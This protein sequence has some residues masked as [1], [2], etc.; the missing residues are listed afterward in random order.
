M[1]AIP[2]SNS[3]SIT[4]LPKNKV[5]KVCLKAVKKVKIYHRLSINP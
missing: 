5:K 2:T 1:K 3:I 4:S